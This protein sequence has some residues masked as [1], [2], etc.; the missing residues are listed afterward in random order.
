MAQALPTYGR[1]SAQPAS[2]RS[3]LHH[4]WLSAAVRI[5]LNIGAFMVLFQAYKMVRMT[6]SARSAAIGTSHAERL[7]AWE[8]TLHLFV[9][10]DLQRWAMSREWLIHALN[11]NYFLF[12]P[13]FYT[14]CAIGIV[15]APAA[16]R[17]LRRVFFCSM[18]LALPWYALFPLAPPRFMT[19]H[20][21]TDTLA[22]FGPVAD[23]G[24]GLVKANQY[25]AMP[26]MHIGWTTIGACMV[27]LSIRNRILGRVVGAAIVAWMCLTVMATGNHYVL[28]ILG[29]WLIVLASFALARFSERHGPFAVERAPK[30]PGQTL[31]TPSQHRDKS[32]SRPVIRP[33]TSHAGR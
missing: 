15:F 1:S 16:F 3:L 18:L 22:I 33:E 2:S 8:K 27:A 19:D 32:I 5:A 10:P 13:A 12:M 7:I 4:P 31:L 6:F 21:L 30:L 24:G 14:Y 28:D 25:A 29:G 26:S 11:W 20:G 17:H 23:T 9:E